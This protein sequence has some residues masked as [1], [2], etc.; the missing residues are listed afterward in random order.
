MEGCY[1][2]IY[3]DKFPPTGWGRWN[4]GGH[5][6][7]TDLDELHAMA[8]KLGLKRSWFQG[9]TRFAHYDLVASKRLLAIN[10]GAVEIEFGEIPD[11]ILMRN[12]DGTY[13]ARS[14]RLARRLQSQ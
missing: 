13:E 11:D 9:K 8:A 14:I 5:M 4:N 2:M 1:P 6:L 7:G 3:V 12:D 10:A